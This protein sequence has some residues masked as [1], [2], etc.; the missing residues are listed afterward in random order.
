METSGQLLI[1]CP[2]HRADHGHSPEAWSSRGDW[3]PC[4]VS[5]D[6]RLFHLI[7]PKI[8]NVTPGLVGV[9]PPPE[10]LFYTEFESS[11]RIGGSGF[12]DRGA[13]PRGDM[14]KII[15]VQISVFFLAYAE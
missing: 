12:H 6:K 13:K 9:I 8:S 3:S 1:A 15:V 14:D 10:V 4:G 5:C 2:L 11:A 7:P